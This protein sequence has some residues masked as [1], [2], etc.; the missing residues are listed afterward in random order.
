[1]QRS[2]PQQA[3]PDASKIACLLC[4]ITAQGARFLFILLQQVLFRQFEFRGKGCSAG[5]P[6]GTSSP[7]SDSSGLTVSL[8]T[9]ASRTIIPVSFCQRHP[10]CASSRCGSQ[11]RGMRRTAEIGSRLFSRL[12]AD[13]DPKTQRHQIEADGV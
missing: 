10:D 11:P 2:M 7:H 5:M 4:H 12:S 1:M 9:E 8:E 13:C 6:G 3:V